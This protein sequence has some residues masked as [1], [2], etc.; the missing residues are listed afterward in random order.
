MAPKEMPMN[1]HIQEALKL[2]RELLALSARGEAEAPDDGCRVLYGIVM[3][4]AHKIR[5]SAE[6]ERDAHRDLGLWEEVS[7]L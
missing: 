7:V 2:A 4:C 3:D 6:R 5:S 1:L